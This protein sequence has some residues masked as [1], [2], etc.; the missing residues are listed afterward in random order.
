MSTRVPARAERLLRWSLSPLDRPAI[1]GDLEE[2]HTALRRTAGSAA[3]DRWY[4]RQVL[5]SIAPNL[6]RRLRADPRREARFHSGLRAIAMGVLFL[7]PSLFVTSRRVPATVPIEWILCT[8]F[9]LCQVIVALVYRRVEAPSRQRRMLSWWSAGIL[10]FWLIAGSWQLI[11]AGW[12]SVIVFGWLLALA[13][14]PVWPRLPADL[15]A[16]F[17]VQPKDGSGL[18][19]AAWWLELPAESLG[20]SGLVLSRDWG[21]TASAHAARLPQVTI[22]RTFPPS[23]RVRVR[24]AVNLSGRGERASVE[25]LDCQGKQV[26]QAPA[27][28]IVG[29]LVEVPA[30]LDQ[31]ADRDP[32][33]H[34]GL[35]DEALPLATLEPG[36][37][38]LR[39]TVANDIF[40]SSHSDEVITI[41]PGQRP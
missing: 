23:A 16:D 18:G 36:S 25:L 22:D 19:S 6:W 33:D 12:L 14:W 32:A 40:Q 3:A 29:K 9:G 4:W 20:L 15:G 2:E 5:R 41:A 37:Y 11:P 21:V 24:A 31:L 30:S 34:F 13:M 38:R 28:L 17:R 8:I 27:P 26:W 1:L 39:V 10:S 35:I 7:V